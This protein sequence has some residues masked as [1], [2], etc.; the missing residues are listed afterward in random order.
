MRTGHRSR[1]IPAL[2]AAAAALCLGI[3]RADAQVG[4]LGCGPNNSGDTTTSIQWSWLP[5]AG[6]P[7]AVYNSATGAKL[8]AAEGTN[9][10]TFTDVG[11]STN[12]QHSVMVVPSNG[13]VSSALAVSA[14]CYTLAATPKLPATSS[15]VITST[16]STSVS[17]NWLTAGPG[18]DENP[19]GTTYYITL[20][21]FLPSVGATTATAVAPVTQAYF[22]KL[23]PS[24]YYTGSISAVNGSG[25]LSA[26]LLAGATF[27]LPAQ[28]VLSIRGTTP[29]SIT[30][31]WSR[32]DNSTMTFYQVTYSSD[33]FVTVS[34]ALPFLSGL[35]AASDVISG[36]TTGTT[37]SIR[38]QARNPLGKTSQF[39][40]TL[41]TATAN[42][43]FS[44]VPTGS[45]GGLLTARGSSEFSGSIGVATTYLGAAIPPRPIDLRSPGGAFT[46]DASVTISTYNLTDSGHVSC[47]NFVAGV[48]GTGVALSVSA[49]PALQPSR[50]LYLTAGYL[51]SPDEL[52][53]ASPSAVTLARFDPASGTCVPVPTSFNT[54]AHTFAAALN[55]F[56]LY[57]LVS[58]PLATAADTARIF[59][60]PYRAATDGFVT[61][62]RV[63]PASRVRVFT[64]RGE[65]ILDAV[66]NGSGSVTW[67]ADN[68][69]GRPVASG[70]YLVV[71]ESG[72]TK[73]ILKLAVVR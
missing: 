40:F 73:K 66:A 55:H 53:G 32:N 54:A 9:D 5:D 44:D 33:N 50:P 59:P 72:G 20:N 26:P 15:L 71:V 37:Y 18:G 11:L 16:E 23:H 31:D 3:A 58:V 17:F 8:T 41:T 70:L 27:T 35:N 47:P 56:S 19:S 25:V 52:G 42:G 46:A 36:L 68:T 13:A 39:S 4:G 43:P 61:I 65:R 22:N 7:Y 21:A 51:T 67:L 57:Q 14:T 63:P 49:S 34:T 45:L 69:A 64:L 62:D 6:A 12:T 10:P 30:V 1:S 60:N 29:A 38:V 48:G 24:T 28:P 2:L